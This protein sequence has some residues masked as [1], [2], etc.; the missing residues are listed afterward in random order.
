MQLIIISIIVTKYYILIF[1]QLVLLEPPKGQR[2]LT[3]QAE[4]V[5]LHAG[6]NDQ[7][8]PLISTDEGPPEDAP[9][10]DHHA[11]GALDRLPAVRQPVVEGVPPAANPPPRPWRE[12]LVCSAKRLVSDAEIALV[13]LALQ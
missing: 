9:P 12:H 5:Q 4:I 7:A 10:L 13:Q 8:L 3:I 11:E 1:G 6:K 2:D